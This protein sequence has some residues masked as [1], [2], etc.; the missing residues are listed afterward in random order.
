MQPTNDGG[1]LH[2]QIPNVCERQDAGFLEQRRGDA[3]ANQRQ[4]TDR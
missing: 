4:H 1:I 3:V 2:V